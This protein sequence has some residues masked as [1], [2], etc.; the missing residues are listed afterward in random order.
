M[1]LWIVKIFVVIII[2]NMPFQLSSQKLKRRF[3]SGTINGVDTCVLLYIENLI[4]YQTFGQHF[5]EG[6]IIKIAKTLE[7][8]QFSEDWKKIKAKGDNYANLTKNQ[9]RIY[10]KYVR[11]ELRLIYDSCSVLKHKNKI[12]CENFINEQILTNKIKLSYLTPTENK[13]YKEIVKRERKV[14]RKLIRI[15]HKRKIPK[16]KNARKQY[17]RNLKKANQFNNRRSMRRR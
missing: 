14:K 11:Q 2:I 1:R 5:T 17:K 4:S 15:T 8:V 3:Q 16:N 12:A 10:A 7:K 9:R 6:E 13:I